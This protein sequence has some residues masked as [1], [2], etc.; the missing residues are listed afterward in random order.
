MQLEKPKLFP[1]QKTFV[2]V[3]VILVLV[4]LVRLFI[5]YQSYQNFISKPFYYTHA[6]VLDSYEKSK[7]G[8]RYQV[9]K[10]RS[11]EGFTFYTTSHRKESFD[12]KILRLKILPDKN[13]SFK[14]Y[15]GTFYVKS[16]I[17][18]QEEFPLTFKDSLLK[19]VASQHKEKTLQSFYNAIF[20]ATPL[21]KELREKISMLGVSHL[22]ALSGFHLGILWG[23]VYGVLLLIYRPLQQ[24]FFP[25]RHALFDVGLV[26]V[27][28]LGIYLWFVDFP[29]SL[30]RSYA[31]V[32]V[33]WMVIL[34][35]MELLSFTFLTTVG[36]LLMALFPSLLVSLSFG[37]SIAGVGYI[38]LLLLYTKEFNKWGITLF[39]I[40][41]GIFILMLPVVHGIFG[42][43]SGYQLLSP[44][45]SLL[46]IP[47][48]PFVMVLHLIGLGGVFDTALLWLFSLPNEAEDKLLP[49]W[50]MLGYI[51]LSLG[52]VWSRK[53]FFVVIGLAMGYGMYLFVA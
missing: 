25:Y 27:I 6:K 21:Q 33:G 28:F 47:F 44:L 19:K 30:V 38:F 22:V 51:G 12:H 3:M 35:G 18:D 26:A 50:A 34:L 43:T 5:E 20:F 45:L 14:D 7:N 40:P 10:L 42:V 36:L 16:R 53:L 8:K 15:L 32:L 37:L 29:P 31:M 2:W 11:D 13:I 39:F 46:F 48:Y 24:Q 52:A 17:K 23:L 49:L 41:F 9:L 1:E 4:I